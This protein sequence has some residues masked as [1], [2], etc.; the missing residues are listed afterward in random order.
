LN[1]IK[2][3]LAI[4]LTITLVACSGTKVLK[5]E[6]KLFSGTKVSYLDEENITKKSNVK[7]TVTLN[8]LKANTPGFLNIKTGFYNLY[9]KTGKTGFK[10]AIKYRMGSEPVIFEPQKISITEKRVKKAMV[11]DGYLQAKVSCDSLVKGN[12]IELSCV[13][14]LGQR[15]V[16]D[17]VFYL[18]DTLPICKT[19]KI[20]HQLV[21]TK[22]GDYYELRNLISDRDE[23]VAV[24]KNNGFPFI[25][26]QD[27]IYFV[28][29]LVGN[30][31]VD[32]HMR[33]RSTEDS[34]KYERYSYG[35]IYINPNFSLDT[36]NPT[37]T[38]NMET[39]ERFK[40]TKGYDFLREDA[41]NKAMF[42]NEGT[43]YDAKRSKITTDRLLDFGLFKFVNVKTKVNPRTKRIDHFLNLT[44]YKME[45]ITGEV[46][47]NNRQG[48]FLGLLGKL[49]YSNKNIFGG[50]EKFDL[51]LSGGLET[52]FGDKQPFINTSDIKLEAALTVPTVVLPFI[53]LRTN[54]NYIPKTAISLSVNQTQRI[55]FYTVRSAS[56]KY[57]FR[58]NETDVKTS[59]FKPV[60]LSWLVLS[61]TTAVFDSILANDERQALS[62]QTTLI[63][64]SSYDYVYNRRDKFDP[65]NQIYFK[66]SIESAGNLLSLFVKPQNGSSQAEIFGTPFA[67]F[68]KLTADVRK[69]WS[70][71]KSGSIAT[72]LLV[73]A[74]FAYG[75]SA[76]LPY[77]RQ[78][79]VGGANSIR[80]F[81]L[82]TLG[83]GEFQSSSSNN[84]FIDQT[85]DIKIESSVEYRF[86]I[87]G[88]FKGAVFL[89]A[90]NVWLYDSD[91]PTKQNGVFLFDTF[92]NQIAVGTGIG[93]RFD[94]DFLVLRLDTAFPLRD[95][96]SD[97]KFAWVIKDIKPFNGSWHG[98]NVI[99]NLGIGYP[100]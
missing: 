81:R 13:A 17:S 45:S 75:N 96:Q 47:L 78:F 21:Y 16:I 60:D 1:I 31:K 14:S 63:P 24:G 59:F 46:E 5:P 6:D 65:V 39:F 56:A 11:E 66:G 30:N 83:P 62:F 57:G 89:D 100:F 67:Q 10:H 97:G 58:W 20:L 72:K 87:V 9:E 42:I 3:I 82:R 33:L 44:T 53:N 35:G 38:T 28:D 51:S 34:L 26:Q 36:D 73:G 25:N 92:I 54:R 12:K 19:L 64:G 55:E 32:V 80:A 95:I 48:N 91:E 74:G 68:T 98:K 40:M 4:Y 99:F 18:Q 93:L 8:L 79:S 69:Y 27:V 49:T 76:E 7:S 15:Y 77:S 71:G 23:V 88:F 43:I 84:Q 94:I 61:S 29:T 22:T 90:G 37:D 41:L 85:G 50:A 52:Q 86:P 2:Y 70:L